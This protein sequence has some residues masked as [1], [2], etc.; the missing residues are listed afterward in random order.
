MDFY[1]KL[2]D[3]CDKLI[4]SN[5][6]NQFQLVLQF[7]DLLTTSNKTAINEEKFLNTL[8]SC[9]NNIKSKNCFLLLVNS[10][11]YNLNKNYELVLKLFLNIINSNHEKLVIGLFC[12]FF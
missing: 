7:N 11:V 4:T 6:L 2:Q 12:Y 9:L 5:Q 1:K 8:T 3:L 10:I